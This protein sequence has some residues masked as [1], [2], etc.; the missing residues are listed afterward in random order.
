[1]KKKVKDKKP[2]VIRR[3]LI[4]LFISGS[5]RNAPP[6]A[7]AIY[8]EDTLEE[9]K[10]TLVFRTKM[11][12][13]DSLQVCQHTGMLNGS[14]KEKAYH[15]QAF[16]PDLHYSIQAASVLYQQ[17]EHACRQLDDQRKKGEF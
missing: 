17:I 16:R 4:G 15:L 1:M 8:E 2:R 3:R 14:K 6:M 10:G 7:H 9:I 12:R 11:S 13:G 5:Q